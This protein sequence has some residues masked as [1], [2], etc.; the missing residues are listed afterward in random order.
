MTINERV[1]YLRRDILGLNQTDFGKPI[2]IKQVCVSWIERGQRSLT[3]RSI[4]AICRQWNVRE[5][6]LRT[7]E[8]EVFSLTRPVSVREE[9]LND[10]EKL[11][12][13]LAN[14]LASLD[15]VQLEVFK[16]QFRTPR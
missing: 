7:G 9:L 1:R 15:A 16:R 10:P 11:D 4:E 8:G 12:H 13:A 6:W 5:Q 2:H 14:A 3:E